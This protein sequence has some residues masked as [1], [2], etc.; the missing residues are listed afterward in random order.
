M[1]VQQEQTH[2]NEIPAT[3][4]ARRQL[5]PCNVEISQL[6]TNDTCTPVTLLSPPVI[7]TISS[8]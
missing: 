5:P 8:A 1:N 3:F 7:V 4:H 6:V 2:E